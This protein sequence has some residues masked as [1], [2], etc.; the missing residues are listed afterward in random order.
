MMDEQRAKAE[1]TK[2][3]VEETKAAF[4]DA[5]S[6]HDAIV[7]ELKKSKKD[8]AAFERK[9]IK[10]R[11]DLKHMKTTLKKFKV[12]QAKEEKKA[13]KFKSTMEALVSQ[14][15]KLKEVVEAQE[16]KKEEAEQEMDAIYASLKN[17][18][19]GLREELEKVQSE[20]A[21][22]NASSRPQE[23]FGCRCKG[24]RVG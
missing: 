1:E 9:D 18:T 21:P 20:L 6:D 23:Q 3:Q 13:E 2:K 4:G 15:P 8:F 10:H 24:G 5:K 14:I 16:K 19:Q 11:E 7:A 22:L 12:A 17:E